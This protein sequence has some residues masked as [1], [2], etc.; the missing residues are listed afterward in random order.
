MTML[1]I[2]SA[3]ATAATQQGFAG[4]LQRFAVYV[5]STHEDID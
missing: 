1:V 4:A 5:W 3:A 2:T